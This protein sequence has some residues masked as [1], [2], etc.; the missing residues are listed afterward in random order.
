MHSAG[1]IILP[2]HLSEQRRRIGGFEFIELGEKTFRVR[3]PSGLQLG[4]KLRLPRAASYFEPE[5]QGDL[6][7]LIRPEHQG[8][9]M[10]RRDIVLDL[11]IDFEKLRSGQK[12]RVDLGPKK[13]DVRLP[14]TVT[15]GQ[16][17]RL[18]GVGE[19]CNGGY[20]GDVILRVVSA[21]RTR[22][23]FWGL[24]REYVFAEGKVRFS[25]QVPW[26]LEI[27]GEFIFRSTD[28]KL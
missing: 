20:Q 22:R 17:V 2:L 27:G 26:F 3:V 15:P 19:I 24:F 7:L 14:D 8:L 10:V 13:F 12:H 25:F 4:Q 16:K 9:Y 6:F 28:M 18:R 5:S 1:T 11:P 21:T 23:D